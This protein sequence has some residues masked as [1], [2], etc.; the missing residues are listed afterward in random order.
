MKRRDFLKAGAIAAPATM[1][2]A[3]AIAQGKVEWKL[4]TSFPAKAPGVGTNVTTFADRVAAMSDGQLTFKVYSSGEL[5]PPFSVEDAVEQGTA[6]IGHSTPYYAASKNSA[7]HFFSA[8]P[9]GMTAEETTAWLRYGGGQDLWNSIYAERGLVPFY[10]GNSGVQAAGWFKKPIE[11]LNDLAGLNMRIAGLGGEAM[12]KLGVNAVLLPPPEIFP[13]FQSGAIDAAEWVG[14]MLDQAF[15]LQKVA[16]YCY[17]PAFHE[18]S[19]GLEIVVNKEAYDSLAPH[20][21]A[22]IA[23]AAEAASVET[24]AQFDYYNAVAMRKLKSEGITFT[25]FP[26]DVTAAL[27]TAVAEVMAENAASNPSFAEVQKSYDA[28]LDLSRDYAVLM[29]AATYTQRL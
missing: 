15:G 11:S 4:P 7:L 20:L 29:K 21:Q 27:K 28:F 14:P 19:A 6:E 22:I 1:L 17:V 16:K 12:R 8:V 18:P 3:P 9:F 25:A 13:A 23:N 26:Q 10:S 5:V 2:A 24:T